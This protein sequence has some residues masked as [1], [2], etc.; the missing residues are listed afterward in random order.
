MEAVDLSS[1]LKTN[2]QCLARLAEAKGDTHH[3]KYGELAYAYGYMVQAVENG[4]LDWGL[5]LCRK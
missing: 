3:G 4:K 2:Y 1:H 5:Y